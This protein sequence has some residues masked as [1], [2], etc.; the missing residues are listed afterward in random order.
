M[1]AADSSIADARAANHTN[2]LCYALSLA[3]CPIALLVGDLAA[4]E[5]Y[6]RMLLDHSTRRAL[7]VW[8]AWG[9]SYQG[10]LLIERGD[11]ATGLGLLRAGLNELGEASDSRSI[12]HRST[13]SARVR[14]PA[15][16]A[17]RKIKGRGRVLDQAEAELAAK[18]ARGVSRRAL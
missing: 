6:V 5:H 16:E 13:L 17:A 9:R 10:V 15:R 1:R 18:Q 4:A 3:A 7:A 14:A 8:Q 12:D 2:S 11:S